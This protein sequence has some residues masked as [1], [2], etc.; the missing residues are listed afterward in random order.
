M[1]LLILLKKSHLLVDLVLLMA[2]AYLSFYLSILVFILKGTTPKNMVNIVIK[3]NK[4]QY[5]QKGGTG[6]YQTYK[7]C[8]SYN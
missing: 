8:E 1:N 5:L 4:G 2:F 3:A 6:R 7:Y